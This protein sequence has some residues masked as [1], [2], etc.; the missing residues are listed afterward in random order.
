MRTVTPPPAHVHGTVLNKG[1]PIPLPKLG[2]V[3]KSRWRPGERSRY[4]Y[5]DLLLAG[6]SRDPIPVEARFSLP[7]QTGPD[8]HPVSCTK[9]VRS[10]SRG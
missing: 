8:D 7:V 4:E 6:R 1:I 10:P 2:C 9:D 5:S 3:L